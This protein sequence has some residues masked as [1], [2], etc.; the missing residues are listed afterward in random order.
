[1]VTQS[2]SP[3]EGHDIRKGQ[4]P[5]PTPSPLSSSSGLLREI[6]STL[7]PRGFALMGPS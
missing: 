3:H 7:P 5:F 6:G 2:Q 1:M 4:P